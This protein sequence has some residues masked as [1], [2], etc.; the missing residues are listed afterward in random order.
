MCVHMCACV[1]HINGAHNMHNVR[2]YIWDMQIAHL[3]VR[4]V[5]ELVLLVSFKYIHQITRTYH[6]IYNIRTCVSTRERKIPG[7][8]CVCIKST[9]NHTPHDST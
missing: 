6:I 7:T 5:R 2:T 3:I 8:L 9:Y 1:H 4:S